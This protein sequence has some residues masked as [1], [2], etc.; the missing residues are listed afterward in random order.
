VNQAKHSRRRFDTIF[1]G[2]S[3]SET[4]ARIWGDVYGDDH[5]RNATPFSFVTIPELRWLATALNVGRGHAFVDLAC[6]CGGPGLWVAQQTGAAL[7]GIDSSVVAIGAASTTART[8]GASADALFVVADAGATGL[9]DESVDA[10]MSVDALQLLP[11]RA[12]VLGEVAR[13]LKPG[14]RFA[15]TTWLSL[16]GPAAPPFPMDYELLL[17]GAGLDLEVSAEPPDWQGRELAVFAGIRENAAL[18][19]AELGEEV[20]AML[21]KEAQ[22][23]PNAYALMRRVNIMATKPANRPLQ[24]TSGG[25]VGVE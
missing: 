23:V 16:G 9:C 17:R 1:A 3:S 18:L 24:P 6:G 4:L 7:I 14:G 12:A 10:A 22:A 15:F 13:L 8:R 19:G 2:L 5:P 11:H 25:Q 21:V 20:A